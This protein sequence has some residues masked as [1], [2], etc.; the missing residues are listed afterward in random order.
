[1]FSWIRMA[2]FLLHNVWVCRFTGV[3]LERHIFC[4]EVANVM[5]LKLKWVVFTALGCTRCFYTS[6]RLWSTF[7]KVTASLFTV[8]LCIWC[9]TPCWVKKKAQYVANCDNSQAY[10]SVW[11]LC[12]I[13][14][15]LHQNVGLLKIIIRIINNKKNERWY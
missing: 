6:D 11:L 10:K 4:S 5:F 3:E 12:N 7:T 13:V 14:P 9:V 1:M 8:I 15:S 2:R